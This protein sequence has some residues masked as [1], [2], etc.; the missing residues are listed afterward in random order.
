MRLRPVS[1][2][3]ALPCSD[4]R[5]EIASA[6][7]S[8]SSLDS[9]RCVLSTVERLACFLP[10]VAQRFADSQPHK[11]SPVG[12]TV[13]DFHTASASLHKSHITTEI[14]DFGVVAR[15]KRLRVQSVH[16]GFRSIGCEISFCP[17]HFNVRSLTPN[18]LTGPQSSEGT[19]DVC[20][21]AS[22]LNVVDPTLVINL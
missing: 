15:E 21:Y 17:D 6:T 8:W 10:T 3:L 1:A 9:S 5:I 22:K 7:L 14:Q 18:K 20:H 12:G 4:H 16:F 11:R 2:R 13:P 19:S